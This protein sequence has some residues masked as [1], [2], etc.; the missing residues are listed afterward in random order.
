MWSELSNDVRCAQY[1]CGVIDSM[2]TFFCMYRFIPRIPNDLLL[3][4]QHDRHTD[5]H[6]L[7]IHKLLSVE[8]LREFMKLGELESNLE[9][10]LDY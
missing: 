6:Y 9:I 4:R 3:Y 1:S 8:R 7:L 5:Q 10:Q 2:R